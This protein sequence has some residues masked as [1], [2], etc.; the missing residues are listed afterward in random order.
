MIRNKYT[1][2]ADLDQVTNR[3]DKIMGAV[4]V[5]IG[6]GFVTLL[7]AVLSPIIDAWRFRSATYAELVKEV[8]AQSSKLDLLNEKLEKGRLNVASSTTGVQIINY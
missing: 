2:Q 7:I 3:F 6:L 8:Q 1:T 4:I 5:V